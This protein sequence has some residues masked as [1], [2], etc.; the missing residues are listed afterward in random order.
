[1]LA[2]GP[3]GRITVVWQSAP[4]EIYAATGQAGAQIGP[5][6]LLASNLE[7]PDIALTVTTHDR[8]V[9]VWTNGGTGKSESVIE[10]ATSS[11]GADFTDPQVISRTNADIDEC[12]NLGPLVPDRAGGALASWRCSSTSRGGVTEYSRYVGGRGS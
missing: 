11:D 7:H 8:A 12:R 9:A 10:A 2:V 1:M 3:T 5:A 6:H 4:G